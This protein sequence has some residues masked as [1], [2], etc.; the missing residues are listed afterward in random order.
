MKKIN[1]NKRSLVLVVA[2]LLVFGMACVGGDPVAKEYQGNWTGEDG[3]TI[4][5]HS[6][7]SAGFKFGSK[8]VD[9]G[10][11]E[12]DEAAGTLTISLFGIS[13]TWN[14]DEPPAGDTMTL[15]GTKYTRR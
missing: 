10:G 12:I 13:Q 15:S 8:E 2:F 7:G 3:S 1:G 11:A 5:M 4:Y 9:G 14:I 6:D